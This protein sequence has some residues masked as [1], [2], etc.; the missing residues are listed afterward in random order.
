MVVT[1]EWRYAMKFQILEEIQFFLKRIKKAA[2]ERNK[3][4]CFVVHIS[5]V[6]FKYGSILAS[7]VQF[8]PFLITLKFLIE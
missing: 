8:C 2:V 7:F 4:N 6:F 1:I 5:R 3:L